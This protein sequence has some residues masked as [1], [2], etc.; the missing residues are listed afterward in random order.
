MKSVLLDLPNGLPVYYELEVCNVAS[1]DH[2]RVDSCAIVTR[3]A[4]CEMVNRFSVGLR[5][6]NGDFFRMVYRGTL[7]DVIAAR[8]VMIEARRKELGF[9]E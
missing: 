8:N 5:T 2:K 9:S 3:Y 4:S 1:D 7:A 6:A